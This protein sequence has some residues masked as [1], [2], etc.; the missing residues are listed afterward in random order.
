MAAAVEGAGGELYFPEEDGWGAFYEEAPTGPSQWKAGIMM[1]KI[2][3]Q[4]DHIILMPRCGRHALA[5]STLGLKAAV[6]YWRTDSRL[7]YHRDAGTFQEKTA[8]ANM[9]PV[10]R[11]KQRLVLTAADRVLTSFGPDKGYVVAPPTG[12]I[13]ASQS[14][15]AHDMS[16]LAW[17]LENR[18]ATPAEDKQGRHDPYTNQL[19]VA[20][21]NRFVTYLLGGFREAIRTEILVRNDFSSIWDDRV[22]RRGF[23]IFGGIPRLDFRTAN[24]LLPAGIKERLSMAT[25]I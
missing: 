18:L 24:A 23:E 11:E 12:L 21:A 6:G 4:M 10:L 25:S 8:D 22:L 16:S 2:L 9:L 1:P 15:I 20:W 19:M 5:G 17:L 3:K 13:I 14:V 7:E